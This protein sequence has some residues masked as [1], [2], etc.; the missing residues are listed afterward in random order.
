MGQD[1]NSGSGSGPGETVVGWDPGQYEKPEN[2]REW[3]LRLLV[4]G[5]AAICICAMVVAAVGS[6]YYL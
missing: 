4:F 1:Y 3:I 5:L 6:Y 2:K